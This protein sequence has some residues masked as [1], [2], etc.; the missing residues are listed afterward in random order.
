MAKRSA[1]KKQQ[2]RQAGRVLERLLPRNSVH[3]VAA[4]FV[5][6]LAVLLPLALFSAGWSGWGPIT[7]A[8][9]ATAGAA[10]R[11]VGLPVVVQGN[12]MQ[13]PSRTLAVDPQ[14]TAVDLLVVYAALVLAYPIAWKKRLLALA[15]GAAVLE[16]INIF[17]L[18]G[19]AWAS[20]V[21]ADRQFTLVHDYLFEFGMVFVVMMM[22]AV[23][24]SVAKQNA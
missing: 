2:T 20:E 5:L 13:L 11:L 24:L 3:R 23:A 15:T 12:L 9:A 6:L 18:V 10:S 17:R 21:L 14:C 4:V 7:G 16:V 1:H 22:W 8:I 19:V